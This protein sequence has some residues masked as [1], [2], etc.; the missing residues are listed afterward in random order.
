MAILFLRPIL[1][2]L[3]ETGTSPFIYRDF[4][5][6]TF[7]RTDSQQRP[8]FEIVSIQNVEYLGREPGRCLHVPR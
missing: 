2:L 6:L 4:T 7:A 8:E 1:F 5:F 3:T